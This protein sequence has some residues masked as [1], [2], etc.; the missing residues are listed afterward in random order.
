[1]SKLK[2]D[3]PVL[4]PQIPDERDQCVT[5]LL[6]ALNAEAGIEKAHL[7]EGTP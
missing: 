1:M 7:K 2:L 6:A 4:L 3:L 5:R